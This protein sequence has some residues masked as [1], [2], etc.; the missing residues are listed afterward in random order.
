MLT[1]HPKDVGA[2]FIPGITLHTTY[3]II[4]DAQVGITFL[5]AMRDERP[6]LIV[7]Q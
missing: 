3:P 4:L 5:S 2:I 6:K 7:S 1:A